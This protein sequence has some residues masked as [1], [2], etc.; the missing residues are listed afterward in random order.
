M[1]IPWV[2]YSFGFII[3]IPSVYYSLRFIISIMVNHFQS[4]TTMVNHGWMSHC[5]KDCL[6]MKINHVYFSLCNIYIWVYKCWF[7][8]I[9]HLGLIL[10]PWV[11]NPSSF[12]INPLGLLFI[13]VYN[14]N[15]SGLLFP[16]VGNINHGKPL[17]IIAKHHQPWLNV[18]LCNINHCKPLSIIAKHRQPWLNVALW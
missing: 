15:P 14:I 10:F 9:S 8:N 16:L 2:Y 5:D 1:L 18:A 13:C 4:Q 3:S 6:T 12:S 11:H 17:S 7:Y